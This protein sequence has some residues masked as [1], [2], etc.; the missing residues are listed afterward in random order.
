MNVLEN[1]WHVRQEDDGES[2]SGR[3]FV[4]WGV[5]AGIT[6]CSVGLVVYFGSSAPEVAGVN[7]S[8]RVTEVSHIDPDENIATSTAVQM[9]SVVTDTGLCESK[10]E[11]DWCAPERTCGYSGSAD[12]VC[13]AFDMSGKSTSTLTVPS[14]TFKPATNKVP[15]KR[16]TQPAPTP[17]ASS[18]T[19]TNEPSGGTSDNSIESTQQIVKFSTVGPPITEAQGA[20]SCDGAFAGK[21]CGDGLR[22]APQKNDAYTE[23]GGQ[24]QLIMMCFKSVDQ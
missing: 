10:L 20:S 2:D 13:D 6:L 23:G 15:A 4:L 21:P 18:Q 3:L 19:S 11:G 17:R 14:V 12:L 5:V 16:V 7:D 8:V 24:P 22:C 9:E 1:I